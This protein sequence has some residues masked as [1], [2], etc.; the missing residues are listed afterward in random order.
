MAVQFSDRL[1]QGKDKVAD[2]YLHL[3][4]WNHTKLLMAGIVVLLAASA[5][6]AVLIFLTPLPK[7]HDPSQDRQYSEKGIDEGS[8]FRYSPD[9]L[10]EYRGAASHLSEDGS[11]VEHL[12]CGEVSIRMWRSPEQ[13]GMTCKDLA[14]QKYPELSEYRSV[15]LD[16]E[17][18]GVFDGRGS[19]KAQGD[20]GV[21][22]SH[23]VLWANRGGWDYFVDFSVPESD[24]IAH[25][26]FIETVIRGIYFI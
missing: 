18:D 20:N 4:S 3:K 15:K 23:T 7:K 25:D 21:M 8:Q 5:A 6:V 16:Q 22:Q 2:L 1:K 26:I 10:G 9:T 11:Y 24:G 19:F 17:I 12:L 14:L 13:S